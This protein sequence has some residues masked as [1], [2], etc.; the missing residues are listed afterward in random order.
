MVIAKQEDTVMTKMVSRSGHSAGAGT[1]LAPE[2]RQ[3][4]IAEAA[5]FR[6][7]QRGFGGDPVAIGWSRSARSTHGC[8]LRR[9]G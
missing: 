5:Y 7:L 2:E 8:C 3:R 1:V 4:M 6:A 9:G